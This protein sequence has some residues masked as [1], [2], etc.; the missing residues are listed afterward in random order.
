MTK[1]ER[2]RPFSYENVDSNTMVIFVHGVIEGPNQFK[3]F[4]KIA[5]KENFSYS[6]ILLDLSLIHI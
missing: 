1:E 6:A 2:H 4:A 5:Y 3:E